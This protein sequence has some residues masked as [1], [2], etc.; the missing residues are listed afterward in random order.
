MAPPG[1]QC[2][3]QR[4]AL[5]GLKNKP[6]KSYLARTIMYMDR[7]TRHLPFRNAETTL[8]RYQ[9]GPKSF[10]MDLSPPISSL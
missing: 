8:S 10:G 7:N 9:V 5:I 3:S 4:L 1:S 2:Y 6:Y